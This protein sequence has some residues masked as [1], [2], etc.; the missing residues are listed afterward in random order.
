MIRIA[1]AAFAAAL[2]ALPAAAEEAPPPPWLMSGANTVTVAVTWGE[3]GVAALL[4]AGVVPAA[5][6]SG[7]IN[8]YYTEGG[9]GFGP[10]E[11]A[12]AYVNVQGW[13]SSAGVPARYILGGWYGPDPKVAAAMRGWFGADV[14]TG[15][16]SQRAEGDDWIGEGG[17]GTG[18]IR[19]RVTPTGE[20]APAVATL[21]YVGPRGPG[22]GL[23]LMK[24]P[25]SGAFCGA[26]PVSVEIE[27]PEG[28]PLAALEVTSMLGGGQLKD[29]VFSFTE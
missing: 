22:L 29:G 24:V 7:G 13:D 10:Y 1:A 26:A 14:Q 2:L 12:Y 6:L 18:M 9:Y 4:P 20:C 25:F 16:A 15:A 19:V 21:N 11:S 8:V 5:D 28:S 3:A 17:D 27:A 23:G